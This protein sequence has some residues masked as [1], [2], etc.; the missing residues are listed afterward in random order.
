MSK[1]IQQF[2]M[3]FY[4]FS[5][6]CFVKSW[7]LSNHLEMSFLSVI[8]LKLKLSQNS[9][10]TNNFSIFEFLIEQ[11]VPSFNPLKNV[12]IGFLALQMNYMIFMQLKIMKLIIERLQFYLFYNLRFNFGWLNREHY[13]DRDIKF[14]FR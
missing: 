8:E 11:L 7:A 14:I 4:G 5:N 13:R 9:T 3:N 12:K 2:L 6:V 10:W 1:F